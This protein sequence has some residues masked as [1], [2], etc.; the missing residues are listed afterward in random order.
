MNLINKG[1]AAA[2]VLLLS[3]VAS[4]AETAPQDLVMKTTEHVMTVLNR[5]KAEL[6]KDSTRIYSL[7]N[8][9]VLPHFDFERIS[10]WV[11]GK[12]WRRA[13]VA[14]RE[15]FTA[16]FRTL[17]VRTYGKALLEYSEQKIEFL[18]MRGKEGDTEVTVRSEI[19]QPGAFPIPID[20]DLHLKDGVWKVYD[21]KI[22]SISLVANYRST[23]GSE[24]SKGGL[25][26]L[27][28]NLAKRNKE[29]AS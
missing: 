16:E 17:L 9:Y 2:L 6:E 26:T 19:E 18:P 11:L 23:F 13:D 24:I 20:Y 14:S 5:D 7:I 27:I 3:S 8:E 25:D 12:Y 21:V 10:K 28:N 15:Q 22:D 4:A 29:A 1:V